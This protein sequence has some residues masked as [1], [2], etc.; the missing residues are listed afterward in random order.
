M[1]ISGVLCFLFKGAAAVPR[2]AVTARSLVQP[3]TMAV[4]CWSSLSSNSSWAS[5]KLGPVSNV[6]MLLFSANTGVYCWE[7]IVGVI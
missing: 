1:C 4:V 5:F 7:V 2:V 6:M 3:I